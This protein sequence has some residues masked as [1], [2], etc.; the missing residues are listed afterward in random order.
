MSR[1]TT[2]CTFP[3]QTQKDSRTLGKEWGSRARLGN[4]VSCIPFFLE[5]LRGGRR[6]VFPPSS[7]S[8][9]S[10]LLLSP[11]T[12]YSL[13]Y[14]T[15]PRTPLERALRNR[16]M[17]FLAHRA[18]RIF[19]DA[20]V[21]LLKRGVGEDGSGAGGQNW[22]GRRISSVG[23]AGICFLAGETWLPMSTLSPLVWG[24]EEARVGATF[25]SLVDLVIALGWIKS[26]RMYLRWEC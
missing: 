1:S 12:L 9:S 16:G 11:L 26:S 23:T 19:P 6:T 8:S 17:S 24:L 25:G 7:S 5:T 22:I 4:C 13:G 2:C 15:A 21:G 14:P 10:F 18:I 3:H 20:C